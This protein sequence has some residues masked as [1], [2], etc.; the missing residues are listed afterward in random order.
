MISSV[1]KPSTMAIIDRLLGNI[2][3]NVTTR[4]ERPCAMTVKDFDGLVGAVKAEIMLEGKNAIVTSLQGDVIGTLGWNRSDLIG[5]DILETLKIKK[6]VV[7]EA[8][9]QLSQNG[10]AL[11]HNEFKGMNGGVY[12]TTSILLW[13]EVGKSVV[14]FIFRG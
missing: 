12:K 5:A 4:G 10:W 2:R 8:Y 7:D 1:S 14:E 6:E 3:E 9:K 11:K 13:R